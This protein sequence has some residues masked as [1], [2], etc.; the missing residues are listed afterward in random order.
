[1]RDSVD[2]DGHTPLA[3]LARAPFAL[4]KG[5]PYHIIP[6]D[7]RLRGNDAGVAGMTVVARK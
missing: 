6:L 5:L 4:R 3:S 1:M 2:G 7:S